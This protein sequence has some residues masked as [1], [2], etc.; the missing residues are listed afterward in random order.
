M[1]R[2]FNGSNTAKTTLLQLSRS[3]REQADDLVRLPAVSGRPTVYQD[4]IQGHDRRSS[5]T[6]TSEEYTT[7]GVS[8][9]LSWSQSSSS[10]KQIHQQMSYIHVVYSYDA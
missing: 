7:W 8:P 6:S 4:S 3:L 2:D 5:T 1:E 9:R 10:S